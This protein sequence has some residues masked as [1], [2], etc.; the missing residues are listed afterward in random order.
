MMISFLHF[1]LVPLYLGW[2]QTQKSVYSLPLKVHSSELWW[3]SFTKKL[4]KVCGYFTH[5]QGKYASFKYYKSRGMFLIYEDRTN[6]LDFEIYGSLEGMKRLVSCYCFNLWL[7]VLILN[8]NF[9]IS[10]GKKHRIIFC[11]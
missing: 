4:V 6:V 5:I 8:R 9:S 7:L 10:E 2:K 11:V 1:T 3:F